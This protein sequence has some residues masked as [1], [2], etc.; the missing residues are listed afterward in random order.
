MNVWK[1]ICLIITIALLAYPTFTN[2]ADWPQWLGPDRNGISK[3]TGLLKTWP[4]DGPTMRWQITNL[5]GGY[6]T[7]V[8]VSDRLYI[9]A[10][11]GM[12]NEY[13]RALDIKNGQQIWSTRI[14]KVGKPDQKPN[15]PGS[16]STPSVDG[17]LLYV[18]GSDGNLACLET[19]T[20]KTRWHLNVRD[21]FN[22]QPGRWAYSESPLIDGDLLICAPGGPEATLIALNKITGD[23][24][25][26]SSIPEGGQAAYASTV[27]ATILGKKQYVHFLQKSLVGVDATNG[28]VLW[29]Y[30]KTSEGSPANIPTPVVHNNHVYSASNRGGGG[31]VKIHTDQ[32]STSATEIYHSLKLPR[33]VGGALLINGY[34]YGTTDKAM[35]CVDFLTGEVK[36]TDRSVG[37]GAPLFANGR[38]YIHSEKGEVAL[39][40]PTPDEYRELGRFTPPNQPNEGQAKAWAYPVVANGYL[41][42]RDTETLSCYDVKEKE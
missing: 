33:A 10:N 1:K 24:V 27:V 12:D 13:V 8:V 40:D 28:K 41:Y 20:G 7:P 19:A 36:W 42:I 22:G 26:K 30:A 3:E 29:Q 6:G 23:L 4:T 21:K 9:L 38:I 5:G 16:R 11:E 18:F 32:G 14:G 31:L 34:L 35:Q 37:S 25:W 2:A 15:Y 17:N 39:I